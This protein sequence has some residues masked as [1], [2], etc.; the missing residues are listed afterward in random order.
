MD[1]VL[2]VVSMMAVA[3]YLYERARLTRMDSYAAADRRARYQYH[4]I[5]I[6]IL[7]L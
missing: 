5:T 2:G 7:L 3:L 6:H 1:S 4:G